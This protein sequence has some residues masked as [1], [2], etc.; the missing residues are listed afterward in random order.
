MYL[1]YEL[2]ECTLVST[3]NVVEMEFSLESKQ[4]ME[5]KGSGV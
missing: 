3:E 5:D 1:R 2:R 4:V